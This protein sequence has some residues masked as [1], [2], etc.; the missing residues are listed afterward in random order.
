MSS[1]RAAT[2]HVLAPATRR[3]SINEQPQ[4]S[5]GRREHGAIGDFTFTYGLPGKPGYRYARPFDYF[6][7][8]VTAVTT[9]TLEKSTH[10]AC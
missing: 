9:N 4:R 10:A 2:G 1:S 8:H 5:I 7:F 3:P 6:D